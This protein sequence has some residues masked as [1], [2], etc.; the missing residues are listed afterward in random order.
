MVI[1]RQKKSFSTS[2]SFTTPLNTIVVDQGAPLNAQIWRS[3][4]YKCITWSE[5]TMS[6]MRILSLPSIATSARLFS[7]SAR[8]QT[9]RAIIYSQ[10][11]QPADVLR[12]LT[13]PNLTTPPSPQTNI[14]KISTMANSW[15]IEVAVLTPNRWRNYYRTTEAFDSLDAA[16]PQEIHHVTMVWNVLIL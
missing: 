4:L 7:T 16:G 2:T 11:G 5:N 1:L 15:M 9:N 14:L 10:N 8:I 6:R 13:I 12:A 3:H